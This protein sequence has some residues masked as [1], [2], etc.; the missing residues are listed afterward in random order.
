MRTGPGM[1]L[2]LPVAVE[3][4]RHASLGSLLDYTSEQPLAPGTLVRVPLGRRDVPGVVWD[5]AASSLPE[6]AELRPIGAVLCALPP[7][8]ADWRGLID[9]AAGYYQRSVGELALAVLPPE[10]RRLDAVQ[11]GRRLARPAVA[12]AGAAAARVDG[13][14]P[15]LSPDQAAV[16]AA[17]VPMCH[18]TLVRAII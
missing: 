4:P 15:A 2:T 8:P 3:A 12:A 9:F 6:T 18:R 13:V 5:E 1:L 16:V 7:L 17:P 11:L 14:A 10:L